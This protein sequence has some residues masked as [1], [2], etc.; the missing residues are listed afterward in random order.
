MKKWKTV[1]C[2]GLIFSPLLMQ[3]QEEKVKINDRIGVEFGYNNSG[4]EIIVPDRVRASYSVYGYNDFYNGYPGSDQGLDNL[5]GGIRYETFFYDNRIGVS[6]GLR[7][8]KFSSGMSAGVNQQYFLWLSSQSETTANYLT[9]RNIKQNNYYLGIPLEFR[10][11]MR[12][13]DPFF[14]HYLKLGVAVNCRLLTS[15]SIAFFDPAMT[16]YTGS[17]EEVIGKPGLF[18][19]FIYPTYGIRLGK[20]D[21][22]WFNLEYTFPILLGGKV[23]SLINPYAGVGVQLSVQIPLNKKISF[24]HSSL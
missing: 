14:N 19:T 23:H 18:N 9:I 20:M 6:A 22:I 4:G 1:I 10:F 12:K 11:L 24:K 17:V 15:N 13:H 3:A 8:S 5:Y 21:D 2:C 16:K 7:F